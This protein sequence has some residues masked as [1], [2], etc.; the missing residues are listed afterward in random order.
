MS[1]GDICNFYRLMKQ[2]IRVLVS[3]NYNIKESDLSSLLNIL[4]KTR[5]L[6]AHDERLYNYEFPAYTGINDTIYHKKLNL[7]KENNRYIIGKNDLYPVVIAL[8]L[9]L[10]TEDYDK[11]HHKLFSRMM[12]IKSKL[13]TITFNELL[14][15]MQFPENWHDISKKS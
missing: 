15:S 3:M 12:S 5:N 10:N 11:F 14:L 1:F 7:P 9:L 4:S 8:K 13:K 6:C 2:K